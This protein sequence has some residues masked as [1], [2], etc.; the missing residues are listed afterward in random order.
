[1]TLLSSSRHDSSPPDFALHALRKASAQEIDLESLTQE[2]HIKYMTAR[3]ALA[4]AASGHKIHADVLAK[5]AR[6]VQN[7][8]DGPSAFDIG[9]A[10][11]RA[12]L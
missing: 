2:E 5:A 12:G 7:P 10:A 6:T 4:L 11:G 1:M 9:S 3:N 8:S